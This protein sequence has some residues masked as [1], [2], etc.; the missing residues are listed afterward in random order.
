MRWY[1][2]FRYAEFSVHEMKQ[3]NELV[4][5]FV[6]DYFT[7]LDE[8]VL[9]EWMSWFDATSQVGG[10]CHIPDHPVQD[11]DYAY[12]NTTLMREK[13]LINKMAGSSDIESETWILRA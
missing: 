9:N 7:N 8:S 10:P 6:L 11:G 4:R 3:S 2:F 5:C 13:D 1:C 12:P